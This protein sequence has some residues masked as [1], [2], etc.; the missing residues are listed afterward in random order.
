MTFEKLSGIYEDHY[1]F[2]QCGKLKLPISILTTTIIDGIS[3][4]V[5]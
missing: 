5:S 3:D 1:D 2:F 4:E